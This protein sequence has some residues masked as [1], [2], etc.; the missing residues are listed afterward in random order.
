MDSFVE[1]KDMP[2]LRVRADMRGAG[3][4]AAFD[5]LESKLPTLKGRHFYGA[6]R[7]VEGGEE[8]YA[9]VEQVST[10]EPL[11]MQI[12]TG[13]LPGGTYVR[14]KL[15][16]E[17]AKVAAFAKNFPQMVKA[18]ATDPERPQLEYYRSE[19]EWHLLVPVRSRRERASSESPPG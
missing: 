11:T 5:L 10:D 14:R 17:E 1:R 18:Y 13:T 12:E 3:P 7:P 2:V 6:F 16:G 15:L 19:K 4:P 8:Y 9:C